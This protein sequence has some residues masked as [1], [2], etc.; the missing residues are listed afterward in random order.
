MLELDALLE[1]FV[2]KRYAQLDETQR[3]VFQKILEYPDQL[4]FDYFFGNSTPADKEVSDVI[5]SIRSA[6]TA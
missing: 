4:L 6:A 2:D 1:T 3:D 5:K